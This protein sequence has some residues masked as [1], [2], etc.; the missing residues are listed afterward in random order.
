[1]E[2]VEGYDI[3]INLGYTNTTTGMEQHIFGFLGRLRSAS[4]EEFHAI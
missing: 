4:G 2:L 3:H 1:L